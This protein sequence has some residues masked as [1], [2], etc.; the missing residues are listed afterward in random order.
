[1]QSAQNSDQSSNSKDDEIIRVSLSRIDLLN[2][3][4]GELI[5]LNSVIQQQS[6]EFE[7]VPLQ[8]SIRQAVKLAKAIQSLSMGLRMLPVKP[9]IQKLQRV[10][11]DTA[12]LLNKEV[13]L[14]IIGEQMFVDKSVLDNLVDPL[15]HILRNGVDHGVEMPT[16]RELNGKNKRG[17]ITL[18]FLNE[19]NFLVVQ[20]QDDGKGINSEILRT[21]ALEKNIINEN[22]SFTEK[23]LIHL[24]FH[25]GFSTKSETSEVSGRGV[26]MDVVKTN[27]EN[28]GGHV[29]VFSTLGQG[30]VFRLR[31]PLSLAVIEGMI[32]TTEK[33]R[34]V[35]PLSQVHETINLKSQQI[36]SEQVGIGSCFKLRG[37]VIPLFSLESTLGN[38]DTINSSGTALVVKSDEQ[39]MAV[40]VDEIQRSQQ[41]VIKPFGNGIKPQK[42]WIGSCVLGDGRPALIVNPAELLSGKINP[43]NKNNNP[44][45]VA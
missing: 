11:R 45:V 44:G 40:S 43:L 39:F 13:K 6:L 29:E 9:L 17:Q 25:P 10:V 18:S 14:N 26:G 30:S 8:V 28:I 32:V 1:M 5:V 34:Y 15:I 23:Q 37:N 2:D 12:N 20:I 31:I 36:F 22:Q 35:I 33:N 42:G 41:I 27:V 24:I 38:K 4:V 19:G 7:S 3:Y 21:K 16:E